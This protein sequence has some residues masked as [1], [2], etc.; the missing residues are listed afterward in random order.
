MELWCDSLKKT[1]LAV[2]SHGSFFAFVCVWGGGIYCSSVDANVV[3]FA[4]CFS[5]LEGEFV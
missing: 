1:F 3:V 5:D 4:A 2:F